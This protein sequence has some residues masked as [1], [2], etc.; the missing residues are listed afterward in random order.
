MTAAQFDAMRMK[1]QRMELPQRNYAT[2]EAKGEREIRWVCQKFASGTRG[3]L[4]SREGHARGW[5]EV[6]Q[7]ACANSAQ[8]DHACRSAQNRG[9][10]Q[11]PAG[12]ERCATPGARGLVCAK[13]GCARS[14]RTAKS[15]CA[16]RCMAL[17]CDAQIVRRLVQ[18]LIWHILIPAISVH[19]QIN[20][21]NVCMPFSHIVNLRFCTR[22]GRF[23]VLLPHPRR[24]AL[25]APIVHG[26]LSGTARR[27]KLAIRARASMS[28]ALS[29][30]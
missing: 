29:V 13:S 8:R 25:R 5:D 19:G 10:G 3:E 20:Q 22:A 1:S 16:G 17:N 30:P 24:I 23:D 9:S 21:I 15:G 6:M 28:V 2:T 7:P 4:T 18:I 14:G 27:V 12:G 11:I 26:A